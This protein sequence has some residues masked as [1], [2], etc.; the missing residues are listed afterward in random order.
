[1]RRRLPGELGRRLARDHVLGQI[2]AL[3]GSQIGRARADLQYRLAEATRQLT[4]DVRRR[5]RDST[6]RLAAALESAARSR[7]QTA[8]EVEIRHRELSARE[9]AL[10]AVLAALASLR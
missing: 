7:G 9:Q 10:R 3:A 5:Y 8:A 1:V 2:A 4:A 6:D